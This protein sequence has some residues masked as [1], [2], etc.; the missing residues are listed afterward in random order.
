MCNLIRFTDMCLELSFI[1]I[2]AEH[3]TRNDTTANLNCLYC[4]SVVDLYWLGAVRY[5]GYTDCFLSF[6]GSEENFQLSA[7]LD[8]EGLFAKFFE[9]IFVI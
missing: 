2:L 3:N 6:F 4:C 5:T 7:Q 8:Q 9:L 1:I